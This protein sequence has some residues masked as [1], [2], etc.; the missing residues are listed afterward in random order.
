MQRLVCLICNTRDVPELAKAALP[1]ER[2]RLMQRLVKVV[3]LELSDFKGSEI[4][5]GKVWSYMVR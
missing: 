4:D 3:G 2:V 1:C 5:T